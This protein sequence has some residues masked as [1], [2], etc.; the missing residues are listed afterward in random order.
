MSFLVS[1]EL[2]ANPNPKVPLAAVMRLATKVPVSGRINVENEA[3]SH[4]ISVPLLSEEHREVPVVGMRAGVEH[5]VTLEL[6]DASGQKLPKQSF[7]YT[8]PQLSEDLRETP[9]LQVQTSRPEVMEPGFLFLSIR[10]RNVTRA[11]WWTD[12]QKRFAQRWSM[13]VALDPHGEIVWSFHHDFRISGIARLPNGNMF[14]HQVN[15]HSFEIDMLGNVVR[16]WVAANR[17][18]GPAPDAI[19][20]DVASLHH[21][22]HLLPNGNFLAMAAN[23]RV[24]KDYP[25]SDIDPE[26]PRKDTGVVG[27]RIIEFSQSGEIVWSWDSFDHLDPFRIGYHTFEPYWD[28]RGFPEHADWTHGNGVY[29]DKTDD[30]ILMSLKHQDAILKVD[31]DGEV[32]WILGHHK[33]W[34]EAQKPKL[35]TPVGDLR[36][37]WHGHNPRTTKA[38]TIIMYDNSILQ[39]WPFD[40]PKPPAE[41]FSRAVEFEIDEN[42]MEVRQVW[43]SESDDPADNVVSWAMGDAHRLPVTDNRLVIDSFCLPEADPLDARGKVYKSDLTWNERVREEWHP[44]DFSYWGRIRE[45]VK[46]TRELAFEARVEDPDSIMGWEVFGGMK[47]P[48]MGPDMAPGNK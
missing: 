45:Y 15:H 40:P 31:R 48:S 36:W 14:F 23:P 6:E 33:D 29:H 47:S 16:S 4:T 38:G 37:H 34:G 35:L 22:P 30:T 5:K 12:R 10:R 8:P 39:A 42:T 24:I 25:T 21:Q 9:P 18:A 7:A 20:I 2:V 27:D 1:P 43:S 3:Y 44:S 46:G 28:T 32:R 11:L 41:C 13:I 19:P 26:A 17:T